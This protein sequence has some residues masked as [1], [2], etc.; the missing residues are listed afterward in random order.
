MTILHSVDAEL[1]PNALNFHLVGCRREW[2]LLHAWAG[3]RVK[4]RRGVTNGNGI[5]PTHGPNRQN[6]QLVRSS[7]HV[8]PRCDGQKI[9]VFKIPKQFG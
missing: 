9:S 8:L 4:A 2:E 6:S 7:F 3:N 1:S 5:L